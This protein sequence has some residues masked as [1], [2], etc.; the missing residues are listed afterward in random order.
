MKRQEEK[1]EDTSP[2]SHSQ[3]GNGRK[4]PQG[5]SSSSSSSVQSHSLLNLLLPGAEG[6]RKKVGGDRWLCLFRPNPRIHHS[7]RSGI[8]REKNIAFWI[9]GVGVGGTVCFSRAG[10]AKVRPPP[11]QRRLLLA[12]TRREVFSQGIQK[13][14][15][16]L[17]SSPCRRSG[18][19]Q[20]SVDS[21]F[22][23]RPFHSFSFSFL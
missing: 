4:R 23:A 15:I 5:P 1:V 3:S 16:V 6:G 7:V 22:Y 10:E 13:E 11:N 14:I 8:E 9:G 2:L 12:K 17:R 21:R 19:E 20:W 18:S